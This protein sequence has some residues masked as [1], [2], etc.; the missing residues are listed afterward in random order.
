MRG[1]IGGDSAFPISP[2]RGL[3]QPRGMGSLLT[4][5]LIGQRRSKCLLTEGGPSFTP[6]GHPRP[7]WVNLVREEGGCLCTLLAVIKYTYLPPTYPNFIQDIEDRCLLI[8]SSTSFVDLPFQEHRMRK[9]H[10]MGRN[11]CIYSI[12]PK[13]GIVTENMTRGDDVAQS[14]GPTEPKWAS[15][16]PRC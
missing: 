4:G 8:T 14:L 5:L 7:T 13:L 6:S 16:P 12:C 15:R 3:L 11:P 9:K 2:S 1:K 10:H